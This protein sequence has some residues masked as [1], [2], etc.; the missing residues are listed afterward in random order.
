MSRPNIY[1]INEF[2]LD[3]TIRYFFFFIFASLFFEMC[4]GTGGTHYVSET[5]IEKCRLLCFV[6]SKW[7]E[8]IN[9][10]ITLLK[11]CV[12]ARNNNEKKTR[13]KNKSNYENL[14]V[15]CEL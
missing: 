5:V 14:I 1:F 10:K 6:P 11:T 12:A 9:E 2:Q 13:F 7:I 3:L 15:S 4:G 8:N